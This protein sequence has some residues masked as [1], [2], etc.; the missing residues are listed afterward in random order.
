M[1]RIR[2]IT[3]AAFVAALL[4]GTSTMSYA[5]GTAL[6]SSAPSPLELSVVE[7]APLQSLEFSGVHY[8]PRRSNDWGRNVDASS[9]TQIHLGIFDP[10]GDAKSQFLVGIRGG[11]ML[12][13]HL[14]LGVGVDWAH[15]TENISSVQRSTIGPNGVPI[16]VKQTLARAS[17][18]FFPLMAFVQYGADEN[19]Q[20]IPYFG[21]AG[22]YQIMNLTAD[23]YQTN[24]SFDATYGGWGWQLWAGAGVPL[25]GRARLNGEVYYNGGEMGRDVTDDSTGQTYRE[26]VSADGA[27]LRVGLAWG[28]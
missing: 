11:P 3:T 26:T 17:S 25:S 21:A 1:K 9:V 19:A 4:A 7:T 8:R 28:F 10:S 15:K 5:D 14:Q 22:G 6:G 13:Q 2:K 27:G 23:D 12:D 16:T 18:N 20:V 24:A